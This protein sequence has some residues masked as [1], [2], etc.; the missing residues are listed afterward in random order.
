MRIGLAVRFPFGRYHATPWDASVNEGRVEWPPSPWRLARALVATWKV[1]LPD[2]SDEKVM[3]LIDRLLTHPPNYWTPPT[4]LGH[5]RHYM[6]SKDH[7]TNVPG[8]NRDL[9]FDAFLAVNPNEELIVEFKREIDTNQRDLLTTLA[10]AIPYLGRADSVCH[11]RVIEVT[12]IT[13][14]G[15]VGYEPGISNTEDNRLLMPLSPLRFRDLCESPTALRTTRQITPTRTRW[16]EYRRIKA[17]AKPRRSVSTK[18]VSK[19]TAARWY[20]PDAGRPPVTETVAIC[21]LLRKAVTNL[22]KKRFG[23]Q[24]EVLAGKTARGDRL[25]RQHQHAHYL[26]F[27]TE[28]N[29]RIDTLAIWAP[30]GWEEKENVAVASL[31]YLRSPDHLRR[32]GTYRLGLEVLA[33]TD[34]A[35]PELT[36]P[37]QTWRSV[38]PYIP[39]RSWGNWANPEKRFSYITDDLQRELG[40]RDLPKSILIEEREHPDWRRFRRI[41]PNDRGRK[42]PAVSLHVAFDAAVRGPLALGTLSHFGLG[43]FKPAKS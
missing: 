40:Y 31:R 38:T 9:A 19:I 6:P 28:D 29:S 26:A 21:D 8:K 16:V 25:V 2:L 13:V 34:L 5:S 12:P 30:G 3:D 39:G 1:R 11:A 35:L 10:A 42:P 15:L 36:G 7:I 37:S 4:S 32:L 20:L 18:S 14:Q 41:R 33:S 43:L 24:S 27:S 23:H 22:F 17:D